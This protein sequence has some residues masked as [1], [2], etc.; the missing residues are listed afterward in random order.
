MEDI[1]VIR[2]GIDPLIYYRHICTQCDAELQVK[3]SYIG[4]TCPC[5]G[6]D[7][8]CVHNGDTMV[9]RYVR[10]ATTFHSASSAVTPTSTPRSIP[11]VT[12]R[13]AH[14]PKDSL[15]P[16]SLEKHPSRKLVRKKTN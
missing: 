11:P 1:I 8:I 6:S 2:P 4:F 7:E 13:E 5:C 16:K 9:K 15:N 3:N 14:L 12:P 10:V